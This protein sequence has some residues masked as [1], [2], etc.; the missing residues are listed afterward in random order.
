MQFSDFIS[1]YLNN[2]KAEPSKK[3]SDRY[4]GLFYEASR[5]FCKHNYSL[6]D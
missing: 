6:M 4:L 5:E 1:N 3:A 2:V